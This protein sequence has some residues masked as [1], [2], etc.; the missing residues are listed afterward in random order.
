MAQAV[1]VYMYTWFYKQK[2]KT[3][4][5][6]NKIT[7][8]QQQTNRKHFVFP[9]MSNTSRVDPRNSDRKYVSSESP[10]SMTLP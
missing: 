7:Q 2:S 10:S 8:K 1:L 3:N 9:E 5:T 6:K 4:K